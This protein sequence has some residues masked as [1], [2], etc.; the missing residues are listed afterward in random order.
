M[1]T[2]VKSITIALLLIGCSGCVCRNACLTQ[3]GQT[4]VATAFLECSPVEPQPLVPDVSQVPEAA[5]PETP[6]YCALSEQDAQCLAAGNSAIANLL[7]AEADAISAQR[8]GH[9]G[10]GGDPTFAR[11]LLVLAAIHQRNTDAANSLELFLRLAEAEA[12]S[13]NLDR[14][15]GQVEGTL[16][17]VGQLEERGLLSPVSKLDAES[18]RLQL[19]H[20]Q[21]E[22]HA[23]IKRLNHQ[24]VEIIKLE[25]EPG[26]QFWPEVNLMVDPLLPDA[27]E[28][29]MVA[30][31]NRADLAAL[32]LAANASGRDSLAAA[33]LLLPQLSGGSLPATPTMSLALLHS[34]KILSQAD[35]RG[36]QLSMAL[37]ERE[38]A[39]RN[40]TLQAHSWV[41]ARLAQIDLT[42]QRLEYGRTRIRSLEQQR[43]LTPGTQFNLRKARAEVLVIEQDLLHDVIEWKV[44][45]VRL[46]QAQGLLAAECGYDTQSA[47]MP[48]CP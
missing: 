39:A 7:V 12:G 17:D 43:Q 16:A 11:T 19:R 31:A 25:L 26:S 30:L 28:S 35:V 5:P 34:R 38:R 37:A 40:E 20:Q 18:Q 44:A 22:L 46:K 47:Q 9:H 13:Q 8:S 45:V 41:S 29:V 21:V 48:W 10:A 1:V 2:P 4:S 33:Q 42:R 27:E 24:L 15:L 23:T 6:R 14:Q 3:N 32:R 36:E